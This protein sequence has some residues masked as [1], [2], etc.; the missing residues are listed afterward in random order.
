MALSAALPSIAN[1]HTQTATSALARGDLP[2]A[3]R[4]ADAARRLDPVAVDALL[5]D[6]QVAGIRHQFGFASE[7]LT[8]AIHRQPD[9]PDVWL[10]IARFEL[11]RGDTAAMRTAASH[12]LK[13]DP[14][15]PA[16]LLF[17]LANDLGVRSA[18]ATGT[19]LPTASQPTG[20]QTK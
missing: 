3:G 19:P 14:E 8:D 9:N 12:A 6:A 18:T 16:G 7:L 5:L 11:G 1:D 4:E 17:F 13:L 20:T 2:A 15:N 10:G